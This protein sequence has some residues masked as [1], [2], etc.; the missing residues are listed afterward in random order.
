MNL[1]VASYLQQPDLTQKFHHSVSLLAWGL[2]EEELLEK[3]LDR[4][5][6]LLDATVEDYE[7]IFVD[8][9][10]TDG[11]A[12]ILERYRCKEPRLKIITNLKN[13]NVGISCRRAVKAASK[14]FLFWQ[15]VD[16]SYDIDALRIYLELLKHYDVVQ[17]IRPVPER[18]LSYIPVLRSIYRIKGRSDNLWK[19]MVSLGNYYVQRILFGVHFHDF[20]NVTF[21]PTRLVQ[22][23]NLGAV[24][25]FVNPEMLIKAFYRGS[26][27]IEVPI[28]FIPRSKGE[29]KGTKL[30]TIIR[31]V[32]DILKHWCSWGW[33]IR[34]LFSERCN[35]GSIQR[36][37]SPIQLPDEVLILVL[38]LLK[39]FR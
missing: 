23:L 28:S 34:L 37:A 27:F 18:L 14:E 22:S 30:G 5:F 16:W 39:K 20:Q 21:Y 31:T 24:T 17:G 8:D 11:T 2:N 12:K 15:T 7:V 32:A 6:A 1:N 3:F 25:P 35:R 29:A 4:A 19:A 36:V 9:G 33:K 13:V 38:P 10:S 26:R